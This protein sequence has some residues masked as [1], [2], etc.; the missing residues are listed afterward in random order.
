MNLRLAKIVVVVAALGGAIFLIAR[1]PSTAKPE[2]VEQQCRQV[3]AMATA[4]V[5]MWRA[6]QG[7]C[8]EEDQVKLAA[9]FR[10]RRLN[11]EALDRSR[12]EAG[13]PPL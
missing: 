12:R 11:S 7:V 10:E 2:P 9:E 1:L 5:D 13:L 3:V 6:I 4:S 8:S